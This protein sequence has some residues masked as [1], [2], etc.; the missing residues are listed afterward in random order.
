MA[1]DEAKNAVVLGEGGGGLLGGGGG[2]GG[3]EG[4]VRQGDPAGTGTKAA[5]LVIE[6]VDE[7]GADGGEGQP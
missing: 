1:R 5:V 7:S 4:S 3:P 2:P 6:I